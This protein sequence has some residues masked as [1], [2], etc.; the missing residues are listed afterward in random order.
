[1]FSTKLLN[2]KIGK[3][4]AVKAHSKPMGF[5]N[6]DTSIRVTLLIKNT[7]TVKSPLPFA[8]SNSQFLANLNLGTRASFFKMYIF[9]DFSIIMTN[10]M[11]TKHPSE[12]VGSFHQSFSKVGRV[13]KWYIGR[14]PSL[15]T[16]K[17][18]EMTSFDLWHRNISLV[19]V[20]I[21]GCKG[22]SEIYE[23]SYEAILDVQMSND[24]DLN[25]WRQREMDRQKNKLLE[26]E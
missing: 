25:Q 7:A 14:W 22:K 23:T 12:R 17:N 13:G 26:I 2:K 1:M 6:Q 11:K 18:W 4:E 24:G 20:G 3:S 5:R 21:I 19:T 10:I 16:L 15:P 8:P 9:R